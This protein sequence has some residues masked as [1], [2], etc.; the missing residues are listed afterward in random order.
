M[1]NSFIAFLLIA[2]FCWSGTFEL[3][4]EQPT[5]RKAALAENEERKNESY[6]TEMQGSF[7]YLTQSEYYISCQ[8]ETGDLQSPN[9]AQNMR[10][11]YNADGFEAQPSVDKTALWNISFKLKGIYRDN[12]LLLAAAKKVEI[13][14]NDNRLVFNQ[15]GYDIEYINGQDG[16]RQNFILKQKPEGAGDL[17]IKMDINSNNLQLKCIDNELIGY[18]GGVTKYYY[19][20]LKVWDANYQPLKASMELLGNELA[21]IVNDQNADYPITI[22]PISTTVVT[23]LESNWVGAHFGS[24]VASAGDVNGDGYDDVIVGAPD[25]G[26]RAGISLGYGAAFL[27]YGSA[28]GI[29]QSPRVSLNSNTVRQSGFGFS[30]SCAGDVN[31]DGYSDVIVGHLYYSNGQSSEGG[32]H[33]YLGSAGGISTNAATVVQSNQEFATMGWSVACA[34]DVNGDG[35][36]DIIVGA[37]LYENGQ[38]N[39]GAAFIYHGSA[40]GIINTVAAIVESNQANAEMGNSVAGAGDVNGDGYSDVVVGVDKYDN[41]QTDEGAAFVFLGSAS[42]ISTTAAAMVESNQ[43]GAYMGISVAGAGDVNDDGYSDV[44]VAARNYS[45]GQINEGAA[46]IYH[47]SAGGINTSAAS[48]F[49]SNTDYG[50]LG[51]VAGAGDVN[52]DGYSDVII[53]TPGYNNGQ[54]AEGAAFLYHGSAVGV[55]VSR[56]VVVESNKAN[57]RMGNSVAS[58][59][60]VNGDGFSDVIVGA[61][62]YTNGQNQ[63]GAAFL[64]HGITDVCPPITWYLDADN[65]GWYINT[66]SSCT[67]PGTGWR[68]TIP[69]GGSG[70]CNDNNPAINPSAIEVVDGIDNN[71]DGK[72]DYDDPTCPTIWYRDS[73]GD[74]FGRGSITR[75]SCGKPYNYVSVAGDCNDNNPNIFPGAPELGDGFDNDCDGEV[76]EGL[77]CRKLWYKDAD[78]DGIGRNSV[79]RFSCVPL[80]S[81]WVLI[82]GDCKD[83]DPDVYPGAAE[84]CD[85]KNN[86]CNAATQEDC[87]IIITSNISAKPAAKINVFDIETLHV[88]LWPN[89]ARNEL[90]VSLNGLTPNQKLEMIMLTADGRAV[91]SQSIIPVSK[92]QQLR[93]DVSGL[94]NGYYLL[95]ISQE[96]LM[97]TKK[98]MIVR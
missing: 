94:S 98:V 42:G 59:G 37:K 9:R 65:D 83:N 92:D 7:E 40:S 91:Q 97:Q 95:R 51:S 34:G 93:L 5:L 12:K 24:S 88:N 26:G 54:S 11:T 15:E 16:M 56:S 81:N 75:L 45:N 76:D 70:D 55:D 36:D 90:I 63:E 19:K 21:L 2:C 29:M 32:A 25:Y 87:S 85:G 82:G 44:I 46:F 52:N 53:G 39:E 86:D 6:L 69:S 80:G 20:D 47:G 60:D 96:K 67:S 61:S 50:Y 27:Y 4:P 22:D 62:W 14:K 48:V 66:I 57:A 74:G 3:T 8:N 30:V 17:K 38:F 43:A 64:Y 68:N 78:G 18:Q 79:T 49:E 72:I 13:D 23:L 10:F 89:P 35:F 84:I 31:G 28:T 41:G 58:A 73:D 1:K 71:C 33:I 77:D